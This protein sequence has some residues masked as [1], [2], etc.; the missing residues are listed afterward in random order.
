VTQD[1]PAFP[2]VDNAAIHR[3]VAAF[4]A[5]PE[6][7]SYLDVLRSCLQGS[8]LLDA[9]GSTRPVTGADGST[10]IPAG[11][12]MQF[13]A[14]EGPDG[15]TALF[16]FTSQQEILKLHP[17]DA[18]EVQALA[19][20]SVG[21]LEMAAAD[22][23]GWLYLNPGGPTCA[24]SREDIEFA[25]RGERNDAVK[26]ALALEDEALARPAVLDAL[27]QNGPLLLAIDA[28]SIPESGISDGSPVKVRNSVDPSGAPVMLAYTSGTEVSAR[29][30]RDGFV[31]RPTEEILRD[32]LEPPYAGLVLNAGGPWLRLSTEEIRE[33]LARISELPSEG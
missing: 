30:V 10:T 18:S 19:Q 27:A 9:T 4:A 16:G 26:A 21:L 2:P 24:L 17:D 11:S 3:A 8:L 5:Q 6:Q 1:T 14:G 15:R 28:E 12:T 23:Y 7:Q 13:R 32:A 31:A 22:P 29:N 25:L 33:V 20:T